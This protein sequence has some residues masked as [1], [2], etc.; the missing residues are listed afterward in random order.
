MQMQVGNR[1]SLVAVDSLSIRAQERNSMIHTHSWWTVTN[2]A[3]GWSVR[4]RKIPKGLH[5]YLRGQLRAIR[6]TV[7]QLLAQLNQ[8]RINRIENIIFQHLGTYSWLLVD[9]LKRYKRG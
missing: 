9:A 1:W 3:S 7:K 8:Q 5:K 6:G 2:D 4:Y